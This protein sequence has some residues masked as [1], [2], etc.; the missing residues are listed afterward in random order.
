MSP[1]KRSRMLRVSGITWSKSR[2]II[3]L[4][5]ISFSI[6]EFATR[7]TAILADKKAN[8][9]ALFINHFESPFQASRLCPAKL[10]ERG[11]CHTDFAS[12]EGTSRMGLTAREEGTEWRYGTPIHHF[13]LERFHGCFSLLQ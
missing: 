13:L 5:V 8:C 2:S 10:R 12:P 3:S 9:Q 1:R 4:I 6:M 11:N 7:G